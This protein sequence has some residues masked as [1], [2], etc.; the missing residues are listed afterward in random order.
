VGITEVVCES[1]YHL[2]G[3]KT[4]SLWVTLTPIPGMQGAFSK[5]Q[6]KLKLEKFDPS[7]ISELFGHGF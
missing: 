3:L 5:K 1:A 7:G 2:I 4:C 6:T